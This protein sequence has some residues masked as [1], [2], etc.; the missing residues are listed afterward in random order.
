MIIQSKKW[1]VL[2]TVNQFLQKGLIGWPSA[3]RIAAS[4]L[5]I[6]GIGKRGKSWIPLNIHDKL[7]ILNPQLQDLERSFKKS[8][9]QTTQPNLTRRWFLSVRSRSARQPWPHRGYP[10]FN[11]V[12][13]ETHQ[14]SQHKTIER[15]FS[16]T[17]GQHLE[18]VTSNYRKENKP[19]QPERKHHCSKVSHYVERVRRAE[20]DFGRPDRSAWMIPDER[21]VLTSLSRRNWEGSAGESTGRRG[22]VNTLGM[23]TEQ[24]LFD[25]VNHSR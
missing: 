18:A 5:A 22:E 8:N 11:E 19:T 13:S 4:I 14:K 25:A 23:E 10:G 9:R 17:T 7:Q 3:I 15:P 20:E 6:M 1:V 16:E 2:S 21:V 24:G 12:R